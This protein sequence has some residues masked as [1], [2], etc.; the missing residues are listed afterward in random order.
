[1]SDRRKRY[2]RGG[3]LSGLQS[4]ET[5]S[6][7]IPMLN[8]AAEASMLKIFGRENRAAKSRVGVWAFLD[9]AIP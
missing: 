3:I 7:V 4:P 8:H 2:F 5:G 9:L 6:S 1:L